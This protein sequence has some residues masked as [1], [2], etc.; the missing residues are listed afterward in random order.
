MGICVIWDTEHHKLQLIV[1]GC[2]GIFNKE[3]VASSNIIFIYA[4]VARDVWLAID[5]NEKV[6]PKMATTGGSFINWIDRVL[7]GNR[8][9]DSA[10]ILNKAKKLQHVVSLACRA[11]ISRCCMLF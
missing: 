3:R 7:R 5:E 9:I 2:L 11:V 6:T 10:A 8:D 4:N 1:F